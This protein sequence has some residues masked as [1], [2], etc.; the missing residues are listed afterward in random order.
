MTSIA[1]ALDEVGTDT[2]FIV[3]HRDLGAGFTHNDDSQCPCVPTRVAVH[4]DTTTEDI[5]LQVESAE[6]AS[7]A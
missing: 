2:A 6:R 4:A 5:L 7:E 1:E 3:V